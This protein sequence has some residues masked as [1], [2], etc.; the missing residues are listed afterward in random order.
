MEEQELIHLWQTQSKKIEQTL[1]IN[2]HLLKELTN[3][4]VQKSLHSLIRFMAWGIV[5]FVFYIA[6]LV[7]GLYVALNVT[8]HTHTTAGLYFIVSAFCIIVV[9]IKGLSDYIRHLVMA[10]EV[11]FSGSVVAIQ[12]Q[13]AKIRLS[14]LYH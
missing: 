9:N 11:D 4:K 2:S 1:Q 8:I 3:L 6:L 10:N 5:S 12:Q 14:I 13:L 7:F